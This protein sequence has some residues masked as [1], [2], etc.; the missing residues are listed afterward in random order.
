MLL[1]WAGDFF[2]VVIFFSPTELIVYLSL[3]LIPD[4]LCLPLE[5]AALLAALPLRV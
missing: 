4:A 5:L 2:G 1:N 3:L